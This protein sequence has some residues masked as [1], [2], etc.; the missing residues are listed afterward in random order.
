MKRERQAAEGQG[1]AAPTCFEGDRCSLSPVSV[2]L[3]EMQM[4]YGRV[5]VARPHRVS[6]D[7]SHKEVAPGCH[8]NIVV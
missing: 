4:I 5:H 7:G 1:K 3:G 6:T 2:W 8:V